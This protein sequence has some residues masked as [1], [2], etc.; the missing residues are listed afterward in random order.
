MGNGTGT[1]GVALVFTYKAKSM[2]HRNVLSIPFARTN[3][4]MFS[5]SHL[6]H[7]IFTFLSIKN[8]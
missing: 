5:S 2:S 6:N 1:E 8:N 4:A 3:L 7:P